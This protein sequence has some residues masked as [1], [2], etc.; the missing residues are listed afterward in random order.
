VRIL[1][2]THLALPHVG[3]VELMLDMEIRGLVAAGHD[4][5]VVTSDGTGS[6]ATPTYPPQVRIIRVP[7]WHVMETRFRI[8]YPLYSP[9]LI[10]VLAREVDSADAVHAHGFMF[11]A[12]PLALFLAKLRGKPSLLTDHGGFQEYGSKVTTFLARLGGETLGR[13]SCLFADRLH[14]FNGRILATLERLARKRKATFLANPVDRERFHPADRQL[15]L[16]C[17]AE[18]HWPTDRPKV[19]FVGR[20]VPDK[21]VDLLQQAQDAGFDLVFCGA[22]DLALLGDLNRPGIQYLSARPQAE[23]RKLYWAADVLALPSRREGFPLVVQEALSCGLPAVLTDE[24]GFVPYRSL[25][26]LFL[27]PR[28][29]E[30]VRSAIHDAIRACRSWDH[31]AFPFPDPAEWAAEVVRMMSR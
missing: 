9:T 1:I 25:P 27:C 23:L 3:G 6:G 10:Q 13:L 16:Q 4:V 7:A 30:S 17:R 15:H 22:G 11:L 26:G 2:V 8:P 28:S 19:L 5:V 24:P 31:T 14:S 12:T 20:I 18:L 21:G 29:V